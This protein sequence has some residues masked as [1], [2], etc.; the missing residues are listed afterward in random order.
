M[1]DTIQRLATCSRQL[2]EAAAEIERLRVALEWYGEKAA[3]IA[4]K[5][6]GFK[7]TDRPEVIEA[8]LVE[9]ALDAGARAARRPQ[10]KEG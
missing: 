6:D 9:L 8:V 7:P 10:A 5:L 1:P 2:L 3:Y 4:R